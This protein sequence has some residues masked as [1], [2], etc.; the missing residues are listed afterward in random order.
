MVCPKWLKILKNYS[1]VLKPG[2]NVELCNS[3]KIYKYAGP[4]QKYKNFTSSNIF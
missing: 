4:S 1:E 3:G 2:M